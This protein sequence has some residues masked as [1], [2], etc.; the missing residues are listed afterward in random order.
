MSHEGQQSLGGCDRT[1]GDGTDTQP[2]KPE[3]SVGALWSDDSEVWLNVA[4]GYQAFVE[5]KT[6]TVTITNSQS[7]RLACESQQSELNCPLAQGCNHRLNS[8]GSFE[9]FFFLMKNKLRFNSKEFF[10]PSIR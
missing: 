5:L 2:V 4:S 9:E 3:R 6:E 10:G 7:T 8:Y 1:K